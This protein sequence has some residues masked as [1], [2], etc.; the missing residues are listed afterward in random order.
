VRSRSFF[1][2]LLLIVAVLA[3][4][5]RYVT[6]AKRA[7]NDGRYLEASEHLDGHEKEVYD[8]PPRLRADYGIYRGLSLM[9]LGDLNGA[10]QWLTF[11]Y[12]VEQKNPGT[13]KAEQRA[14]LDR[15]WWQLAQLR[16]GPRIVVPP[17]GA[18]LVPAPAPTAADPAVA[19][20]PEPAP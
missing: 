8:L 20:A 5:N 18:I 19:P 10:Y 1:W 4:C 6:R 13:L 2:G 12:E 17:G 14:A 15:G 7:Y 3:G 11:A 9:A 16:G